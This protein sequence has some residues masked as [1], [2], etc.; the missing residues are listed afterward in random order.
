MVIFNSYVSYYQRVYPHIQSLTPILVGAF[1]PMT[2]RNGRSAP[3]HQGQGSTPCSAHRSGEILNG[4]S[5]KMVDL[6]KKHVDFMGFSAD[7]G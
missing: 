1:V 6:S 7:L 2:V 5:G 3:R 4:L